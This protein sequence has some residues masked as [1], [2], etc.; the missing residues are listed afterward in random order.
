MLICILAVSVLILF[1]L[2]F[3]IQGKAKKSDLNKIKEEAIHDVAKEI[4]HS[5]EI[6]MQYSKAQ[7]EGIGLG[8]KTLQDGVNNQMHQMQE[9]INHLEI[10]TR[11][12][13][14]Y[15]NET[16]S[17]EMKELRSETH[18]QLQEIKGTVDEQLQ[19]ALEKKIQESFRTVSEQLVSVQR[20]LGEMTTLANSVGDLKKTLS[21]VKQRGIF[22]EL[23]LGTIL[24]QILAPEQYEQN[25]ATVKG[26]SCPVE[27]AVKLPGKGKDD[28]IY[29]P[30]DSKFP[31]DVYNNLLDA[32]E[33]G[34]SVLIQEYGKALESRIL[35]EAKDI[36]TK[37][38]HV[39]ETTEFAIMFLPTES[40]YAEVLKRGMLEK[41]QDKYKIMI[42]GPTTMAALLNSL[43]MGFRTLAISQRANEVV[44]L[45]NC[46]KTEFNNYQQA[47]DSVSKR[48]NQTSEE[49][50][51]LVGTRT[52]KLVKQL[53]KISAN[54]ITES[55]SQT[56][57][58]STTPFWEN[59]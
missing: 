20:G 14:K 31:L 38:V 30:I 34:D 29:L 22:G 49:F 16:V 50:E 46:V 19:T 24:E 13:M 18:S 23:Q 21:N 37:Y 6:Q 3:D 36:H 9:I 12:Q 1:V 32:Y 44:E 15:I 54:E 40:L 26:S 55:G 57:K 45:L 59:D 33:K 5:T 48:L 25:I 11:E 27:F 47:V 39:P 2:L 41:L 35:Q 52:R 42:A 51:K 43:Q 4:N 17:N 8:F 28:C 7:S 10:S 56:K 58:I 53:D